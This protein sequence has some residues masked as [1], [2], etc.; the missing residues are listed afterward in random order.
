[1]IPFL[2]NDLE[3]LVIKLMHRFLK[4]SVIEDAKKSDKLTDVD[5]DNASNQQP[6]HKVDLGSAVEAELQSVSSKNSHL[7][8][9]DIF[10]FK[11]K[12][13]TALEVLVR[14]LTSKS[15]LEY[16][17]AKY[18]RSMDPWLMTNEQERSKTMFKKILLHLVEKKRIDIDACDDIREEYATY[19]NEIKG[20][21][22]FQNFHR[23][24][25]RVDTLFHN[26]IANKAQ[27]VKMWEIMQQ[28]LLLSHGQASIERGFSLNK[29]ASGVNVERDTLSA[30]RVIKDHI[31]ATGGVEKLDITKELLK[32]CSFASSR[33]KASLEE[34]KTKKKE[35]AS[36]LKRKTSEEELLGLK[37]RKKL[38]GS[39]CNVS[40]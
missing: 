40:Q 39:G 34:K 9:L 38:I 37:R 30:R 5:V 31:I 1:M 22:V 2:Y 26:S 8:E 23:T 18:M 3:E 17:L 13:K 35:K 4:S 12:C 20:M 32:S 21:E 16:S 27:Y 6:V 15:T 28:L 36:S 7:C 29:E 14:K 24:R 11:M 10:N 19:L 33:Y 25:D